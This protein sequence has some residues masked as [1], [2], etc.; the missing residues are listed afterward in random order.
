[1]NIAISIRI[2][3]TWER[4]KRKGRRRDRRKGREEEESKG[5]EKE[6]RDEIK[7]VEVINLIENH[8]A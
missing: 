8:F 4:E 6:R 3:E 1:M 7:Q 2:I 5:R